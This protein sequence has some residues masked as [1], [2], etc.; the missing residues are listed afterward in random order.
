MKIESTVAVYDRALAVGCI[1][2]VA[3][4]HRFRSTY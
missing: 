3:L 1:Q 4:T 2:L